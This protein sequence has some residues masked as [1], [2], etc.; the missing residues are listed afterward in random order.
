VTD[1]TSDPES[2]TAIHRLNTD[3]AV[4]ARALAGRVQ[5]LASPRG[6]LSVTPEF[7]SGTVITVDGGT[8]PTCTV[9]FDTVT[10]GSSV[11]LIRYPSNLVP[12]AGDVVYVA[13]LGGDNW[14]VTRLR[15]DG[16][17]AY[18]STSSSITGVTT[19]AMNSATFLTVYLEKNRRYRVEGRA[20]LDSS[21]TN[22]CQLRIRYA[23]G[24]NPTTSSTLAAADE[25]LSGASPAGP[26]SFWPRGMPLTAGVSG[27]HT[28]G[29]SV[30]TTSGG[31]TTSMVAGAHTIFLAVS[32]FN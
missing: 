14:V 20:R 1:P 17:P 28:F 27:D 26:R 6:R 2:R 7:R 5:R 9:Q 24:G 8:P 3:Y 10:P 12:T 22:Q 15:N 19:E 16:I 29:M 23:V 21:L 30:G 11:P 32:A 25:G 13:A 31:G 18:L 4:N